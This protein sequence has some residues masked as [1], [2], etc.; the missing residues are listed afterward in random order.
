VVLD[1]AL[2]PLLGRR[3]RLDA[4]VVRDAT[5]ELP[6]SDTP[7]ELPQWPESLPGIAPPLDLQADDIRID[8]LSVRRDGQD[9]I[10][11][12]SAR[13]GL[14]ASDGRLHVE[15]LVVESDRGRFAAHGNYAPGDNYRSDLTLSALMP[16]PMGRTAPRIGIVLRGD[17]SRMLVAVSGH[18][19]APLDALLVLS[20]DS[21]GERPRWALRA[22]SNALDIGLLTGSG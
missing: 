4:L 14:D 1:P 11:I 22:N 12:A 20:D 13:G 3:L 16:A 8:A 5:L 10:A 18:A 19:P 15:H 21:G 7:F 17:L 9:L 2:R 6:R